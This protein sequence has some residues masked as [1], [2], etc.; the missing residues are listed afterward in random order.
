M[1]FFDKFHLEGRA[2]ISSGRRRSAR[3]I[4]HGNTH[5]S[6]VVHRHSFAVY[7]HLGDE[8]AFDTRN[9]LVSDFDQVAVSVLF[10]RGG[11]RV[12]LE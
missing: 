6:Q 9:H 12:L 7:R 1:F 8:S 3:V 4:S 11:Q 2:H 5:E 10:R